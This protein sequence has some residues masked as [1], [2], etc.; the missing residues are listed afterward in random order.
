[1]F[2]IIQKVIFRV[3]FLYFTRSKFIKGK[4]ILKRATEF[5]N[6]HQNTKLFTVT[7]HKPMGQGFGMQMSSH[8]SRVKKLF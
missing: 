8:S 5:G 7:Y 1:M 4:L 6:K 2:I 3:L